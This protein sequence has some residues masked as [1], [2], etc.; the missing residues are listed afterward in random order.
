MQKNICSVISCICNLKTYKIILD[1]VLKHVCI[2]GKTMKTWLGM[3]IKFRIEANSGWGMYMGWGGVEQS[4]IRVFHCKYKW[5]T[6][7]FTYIYNVPVLMLDDAY[8]AT[9]D[10]IFELCIYLNY[11]VINTEKSMLMNWEER[12]LGIW[13]SHVNQT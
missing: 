7:S 8:M 1:G 5:N 13:F 11:F 2:Y 6:R 12:M 3:I 4:V 10:I 9:C